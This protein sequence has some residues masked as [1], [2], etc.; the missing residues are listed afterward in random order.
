MLGNL[1][2]AYCLPWGEGEVLIVDSTSQG[3]AST[4]SSA[5]YLTLRLLC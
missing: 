1:I 3:P 4:H 5:H 2:C